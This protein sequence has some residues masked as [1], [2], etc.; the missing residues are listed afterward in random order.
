[1]KN[2]LGYGFWIFLISFNLFGY[3]DHFGIAQIKSKYH[4]SIEDSYFID[5]DNRFF[6]VYDGHGTQGWLASQ[7]L[8]NNLHK[9]I[10][11][12]IN[13]EKFDLVMNEVFEKAHK[14]IIKNSSSGSTVAIALFNKFNEKKHIT[15]ISIGDSRIVLSQ[16]GKSIDLS[17]DHKPN[18]PKEKERIEKSGALVWQNKN[19][20]FRV[21]LPDGF[22]HG[23]IAIS[24]SLG[25]VTFEK[26]LSHQPDI[27][28]HEIQKDDEF[29]I[30]ASDG[31]WDVITSQEAVNFVKEQLKKNN[32]DY[33]ITANLLMTKAVLL[34]SHDDITVIIID[35]NSFS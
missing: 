29:L 5:K 35:V 34:H 11:P 24:R 28:K 26:F 13:N 8:S 6:A 30:I 7:Y 1:M 10:I 22:V 12:L 18:L 4:S 25:D 20:V 19:D 21:Y 31:L 33:E 14:E 3:N 2:I 15:A 9:N 23:G 32:K 27:V 16:N 17:V